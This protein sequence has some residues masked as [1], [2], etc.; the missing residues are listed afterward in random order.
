[1]ASVLPVNDIFGAL[2]RRRFPTITTWN[3]CEA[4]P[5]TTNF[6][7]ALK[8]EIRDALW[9]LTKQWQMGEFEGSDAGS[10]IFAKV[11]LQ[12][13]RLTKYRPD[14]AATELFERDLPFEAKV[15]RRPI[16]L[17]SR[18]R[19]LSLDLRLMMGRQWLKLINSASLPY[20]DAFIHAYGVA[21]PDPTSAADA[22][23]CAHPEVWQDFAAVAGRAMDGGKLYL[24]LVANS[25]NHAYD[26]VAGIAAADYLAID[27]SA[28]KFLAWIARQFSQ[29]TNVDDAWEPSQLEYQFAASAPLPDGTEKVYV[30]DEYYQGRLDWFSMDLDGATQALDAV[31]GST[32]TGLPPDAP[33]T[34]MPIPVS[35]SGSANT[36][37]WTFEDGKTNYGDINAATTDLA[38]LLFLEFALIYSNDWFVI[39]YTLPTGVVTTVRAMVVT[40][41][42]GERMWIEA[43]DKGAEADWKRWSMFTIDVRNVPNANAD[44]SLLLVPTVAKIQESAP[45]EEALLLRDEVANM[46]W[47]VEN[48]VPLP[49][50]ESKR[51]AEAARQTLHYLTSRLGSSVSPAIPPAAP[52]RYD[53]MQAPPEHWI[54]FIPVH[55]PGSN[56]DIQIQRAA[57]LRIIE[58]STATKQ[59]V[60]PRT[61]LLREGLDAG[62]SYFIHEEEVPRAGTKISQRFERTRWADGRVFTWL[63]ARR[64]TGRGEGSS[65]LAF[66]DIKDVPFKAST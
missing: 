9:M 53:I 34:M 50:G 32:S 44:P 61:V 35:F 31:P 8:A 41:V 4:R 63:R 48:L 23:I 64:E 52:I 60:E 58:G 16:P 18:G 39:P 21:D 3:R 36:R 6:D 54:P 59:K 37:W 15:E 7:R 14:G 11:Q 29:P 51:G 13:S 47:G 46:V 30:A 25:A 12:T 17:L 57:L 10:P 19:V 62:R 45:T 56:R 38:K 33:Q 28:Q 22:D 20:R 1:M 49:N 27:A 5:R 55:I 40:N 65:G 66:D 24:H 2:E 26:G 43:A 42:F